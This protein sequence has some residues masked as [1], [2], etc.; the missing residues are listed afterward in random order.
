M[1]NHRDPQEYRQ[2]GG[3]ITWYAAVSIVTLSTTKASAWN[4][5]IFI[6]KVRHDYVGNKTVLYFRKVR[7]EGY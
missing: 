4:G 6:T 1:D 3:E 5:K 2:R 7:L